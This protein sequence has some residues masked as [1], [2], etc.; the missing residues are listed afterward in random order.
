M[1]NPPP[2]DKDIIADIG[3]EAL[4]DAGFTDHNVRKWMQRGIPWKERARV[5]AIAAGMGKQ[6]PTD[7]L[8]ARRVPP[9]KAAQH[10]AA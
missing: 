7:F 10:E 1:S 2:N 3:V 8:Q 6:V 5:A 9:T 4:T